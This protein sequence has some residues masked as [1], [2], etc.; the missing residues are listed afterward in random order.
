[1]TRSIGTD[2]MTERHG[3]EPGQQRGRRPP[4]QQ[5]EGISEQD[6][7]QV[8]DRL[9][10]RD[11]ADYLRLLLE[12]NLEPGLN[13]GSARACK[14]RC[15]LEDTCSFWTYRE[16][17]NRDTRARDCFLKTGTPGGCQT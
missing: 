1:M 7:L 4:G 3:G 5:V 16:G 11:V 10:P 14:A 13:A 15:R 9:H 6:R 12:D 17:D 8:G 2:L